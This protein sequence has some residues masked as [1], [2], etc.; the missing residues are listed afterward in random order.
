LTCMKL[1]GGYS[2][3]HSSKS[4]KPSLRHIAFDGALSTEGKCVRSDALDHVE[5][6]IGRGRGLKVVQAVCLAGDLHSN[7]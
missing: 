2:D 3:S 7:T 6:G 4:V 5:D 1:P